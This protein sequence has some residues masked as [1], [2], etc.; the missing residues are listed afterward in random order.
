MKND[1][2]M[3]KQ[4]R[5]I[6]VRGFSSDALEIVAKNYN[7]LL[8]RRGIIINSYMGKELKREGKAEISASA[9]GILSDIRA[10]LGNYSRSQSFRVEE[11]EPFVGSM[12]IL[13]DYPYGQS[14]VFYQE[15]LREVAD[16][17]NKKAKMYN[18]C[19]SFDVEEKWYK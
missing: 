11:G 6:V 13:C 12:E 15:A 16:A 4:I 3:K 18:I 7:T 2:H 14:M 9:V 10:F 8:H 19:A 1:R 17:F 5:Q